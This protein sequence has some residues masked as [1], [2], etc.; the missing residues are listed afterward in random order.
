MSWHE[1]A[2]VGGCY[3]WTE[4]GYLLPFASRLYSVCVPVMELEKRRKKKT[5]RLYSV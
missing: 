4:S 1:T 2:I 3:L 5:A